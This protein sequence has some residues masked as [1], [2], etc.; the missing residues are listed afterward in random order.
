M[1][2]TDFIKFIL[3][4]SSAVTLVPL[5]KEGSSI[6]PMGNAINGKED[7]EKEKEAPNLNKT[8]ERFLRYGNEGLN[9]AEKSMMQSR[10]ASG[11]G[12][13]YLIPEGLRL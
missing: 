8:F 1:K 6:K 3:T 4:L 12:G 5:F 7:E 9:S 10:F 11:T 2:R 13:G